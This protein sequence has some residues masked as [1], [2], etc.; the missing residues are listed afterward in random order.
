M[1]FNVHI[2]QQQRECKCIGLT[3]LLS[4][5]NSRFPL[6]K[7][8]LPILLKLTKQL[9]SVNLGYCLGQNQLCGLL[10]SKTLDFKMR[11]PEFNPYLF[12]TS[13]IFN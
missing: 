12:N 2:E 8:C 6:F 3:N 9:V 7:P 13:G 1:K 11:G 10:I 5:V 4:L